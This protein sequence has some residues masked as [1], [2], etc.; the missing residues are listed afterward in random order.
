MVQVGSVFVKGPWGFG[1]RKAASGGR[2][3]LVPRTAASYQVPPGKEAGWVGGW[4][5]Q[6]GLC[7]LGVSQ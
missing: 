6:Q 3:W 5:P 2:Y 7:F 4:A 1:A